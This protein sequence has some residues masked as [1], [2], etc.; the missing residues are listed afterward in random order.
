V[1]VEDAADI[2]RGYVCFNDVSARTIQGSEAQW[3][4]AKSFD[5]FAPVGPLVPA[6]EIQDPQAL[7]ITTSINGKVVQRSNTAQMIFSVAQLVSFI[8]QGMTLEPGDLIATG[9]PGGVG[10]ASKPP[11][12]LQAG[13]EV[14]VQIE[15]LGSLTNPVLAA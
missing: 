13:D 14:T 5:T 15:G 12:Y 4:R 8:S 7:D 1:S 9:T 3:T 11:R 2:V 10:W 6:S